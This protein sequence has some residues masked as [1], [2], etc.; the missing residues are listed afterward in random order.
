MK[1]NMGFF[2]MRKKFQVRNWYVLYHACMRLIL[3]KLA[4]VNETPRSIRILVKAGYK[5]QNLNSHEN[6]AKITSESI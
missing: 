6:G 3:F 2:I 5:S 4:L 1:H